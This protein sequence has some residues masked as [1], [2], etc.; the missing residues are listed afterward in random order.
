MLDFCSILVASGSSVNIYEVIN[1]FSLRV[2]DVK[3]VDGEEKKKIPRV[4]IE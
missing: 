2:A 3:N 1:P 4:E